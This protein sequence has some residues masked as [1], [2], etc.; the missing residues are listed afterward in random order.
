MPQLAG[1]FCVNFDADV[2]S[3]CLGVCIQMIDNCVFIFIVMCFSE[4]CRT[5]RRSNLV[6]LGKAMSS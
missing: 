3:P 4:H 2:M 6:K 1:E 5:A